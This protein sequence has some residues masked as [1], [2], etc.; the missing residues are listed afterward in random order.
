MEALGVKHGTNRA[1]THRQGA[2]TDEAMKDL[3][4]EGRRVN[5]KA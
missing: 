2:E 1:G 5:G 4:S 3:R